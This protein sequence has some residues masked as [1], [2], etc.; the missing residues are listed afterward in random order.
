MN[1]KSGHQNRK[2]IDYFLRQFIRA[3]STFSKLY[4]YLYVAKYLPEGPDEEI[5][6]VKLHTGE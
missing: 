3:V 1:E 2:Y 5:F 4:W 6:V